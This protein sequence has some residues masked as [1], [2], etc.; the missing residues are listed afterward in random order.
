MNSKPPPF[1]AEAHFN[2][3]ELA[4]FLL[5]DRNTMFSELGRMKSGGLLPLNEPPPVPPRDI[6]AATHISTR[7]FR[8]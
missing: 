5:V 1:T 6:A 7:R 4:E 3:R 8:L 2:H